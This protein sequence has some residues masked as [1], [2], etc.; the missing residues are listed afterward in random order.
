MIY[1]E[2]KWTVFGVVYFILRLCAFIEGRRNGVMFLEDRGDNNGMKKNIVIKI[3]WN[4]KGKYFLFDRIIFCN[5]LVSV[6]C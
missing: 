5:F 2:L 3:N 4:I 6:C 1:G